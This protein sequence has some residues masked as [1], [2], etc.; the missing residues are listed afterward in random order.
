MLVNSPQLL[1][2]AFVLDSKRPKLVGVLRASL[3]L[4][5]KK[6]EGQCSFEKRE[7]RRDQTFADSAAFAI[8]KA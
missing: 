4:G 2:R 3:V 1:D 7:S 5:Y 6:N 8:S